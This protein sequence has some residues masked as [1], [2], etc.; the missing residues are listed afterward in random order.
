MRYI[1][2]F[3]YILLDV[4]QDLLYKKKLFMLIHLYKD[5]IVISD[6]L[7]L[8]VIQ[9]ITEPTTNNNKKIEEVL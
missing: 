8:I 4:M 1:H 7:Y 6:I 9:N 3:T 2:I 5:K